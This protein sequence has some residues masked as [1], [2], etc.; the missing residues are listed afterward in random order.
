[1]EEYVLTLEEAASFLKVSQST[2]YKL[3]ESGRAPGRKLGRRWRFSRAELGLWLRSRGKDTS[4]VEGAASE[5]AAV[6][7]SRGVIVDLL[8]EERTFRPSPEFVAQANISDPGIY[9]TAEREFIR[10][11]VIGM[12]DVSVVP[13]P[14]AEQLADIAIQSAPNY[15][16]MTGHAAR[17][18]FLSFST[19]GSSDHPAIE[20]VREA[21]R[22]TQSRRPDLAVDGE[23][24]IDAALVPS[25]AGV[26][27]PSSSVAGTANVLIYPCLAAG[28]ITVKILQRFSNCR[29]LEPML[30]GLKYRGTYI[31]RAAAAEDIIDQVRLLTS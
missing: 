7:P 10:N 3:L 17:V 19:L 5:V 13:E 8:K 11:Q 2:L 21:V 18:A 16:R 23:L 22:L 29:V 20:R 9:E 31:A 30:Q 26:K 4:S 6:Q 12:A 1:M 14:T 27:A 28:N 24:Q 25:V 15:E